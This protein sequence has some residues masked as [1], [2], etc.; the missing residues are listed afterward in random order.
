MH[1]LL[2]K[3]RF[4]ATTGLCLLFIGSVSQA[5]EVNLT[6]A[7]ELALTKSESLQISAAEW[8]AAEA[9]YRQAIG[10][11]WPEVSAKGDAKWNPDSDTR[12]AGVGASWTV[13]DGFRNAR[14]ADARAF[15]D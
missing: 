10:A 4:L 13:F 12:R 9:L 2:L 15:N 5:A 14:T 6:T 8:R 3:I 11:M 7:Y 1:W